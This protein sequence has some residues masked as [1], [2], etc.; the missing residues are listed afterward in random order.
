MKVNRCDL[1]K[2]KCRLYDTIQVPGICQKFKDKLPFI[3]AIFESVQPKLEC[4]LKAV[5]YTTKESKFN[6]DLFEKLPISNV[7]WS[8]YIEL[9]SGSKP[10][11]KTVV[12]FNMDVEITDAITKKN[13]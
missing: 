7:L 11:L 1:N 12:C 6:L 3:S 13:Q 4:P 8:L 10:N 2:K 9:F 5:N